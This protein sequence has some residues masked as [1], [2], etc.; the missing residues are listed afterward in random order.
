MRKRLHC[1]SVGSIDFESDGPQYLP[2]V[3]N[4]AHD[5]RQPENHLFC[6]F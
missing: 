2:A 6:G 4:M 5:V 3:P 1:V